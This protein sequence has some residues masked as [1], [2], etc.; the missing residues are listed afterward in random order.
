M[1]TGK[2]NGSLDLVDLQ[3]FTLFRGSSD[4][5]TCPSVPLVLQGN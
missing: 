2:K 5:F 3:T 1:K 4:E